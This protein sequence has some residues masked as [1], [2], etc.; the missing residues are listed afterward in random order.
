MLSQTKTSRR[1]H[2]IACLMAGISFFVWIFDAHAADE[3]QAADTYV[4]LDL[5]FTSIDVA[6][7]RFSPLTMQARIGL[8]ILPDIYPRLTLESRLGFDLSDDTQTIQGNEVTLT[9]DAYVGFYLRGDFSI[10]DD[11]AAY[12]SLGV[13]SAQMKG[14]FGSAGLPNDD[15]E[16]SLSYALGG[17]YRLPWAMSVYIEASQLLDGEHFK[18]SGLALGVTADIE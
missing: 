18:I 8:T 17:S 14:P 6:N 2:G 16:T 3:Q 15:T 13:A 4:G 12:L 7:T 11:A 5:N 9:L 1:I 10:T